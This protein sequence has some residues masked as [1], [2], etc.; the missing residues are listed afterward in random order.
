MYRS[1]KTEKEVLAAAVKTRN[2]DGVYGNKVIEM[3]FW[4]SAED[5]KGPKR[6]MKRQ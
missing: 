1:H 4:E 5:S 3:V 6:E 2:Y